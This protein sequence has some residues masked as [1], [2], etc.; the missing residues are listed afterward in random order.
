MRFR[1][2]PQAAMNEQRKGMEAK[3][4]QIMN[5]AP[6]PMAEYHTGG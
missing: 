2:D 1:A 3:R 4:D 5:G 6:S